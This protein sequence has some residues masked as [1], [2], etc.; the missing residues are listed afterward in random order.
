MESPSISQ[1]QRAVDAW[2]A[3]HGETAAVRR[4]RYEAT[5]H[6]IERT[7]ARIRRARK[8]AHRTRLRLLRAKGYAVTGL[9]SCI[10]EP[11]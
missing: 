11:T 3:V 4:A 5:S 9:P 7:Q 2:I 8:S 1:L 10:R 6:W